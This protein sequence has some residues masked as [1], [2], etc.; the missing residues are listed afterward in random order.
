[1]AKTEFFVGIFSLG[2]L[3]VNLDFIKGDSSNELTIF[4]FTTLSNLNGWTEQSDTVREVGMSKASFVLQKTKVFQRAVFFSLLNPQ[5][6]GAGFAGYRTNTH[7]DLRCYSKI[8]L[9]CRGQ[10][11]NF[12]YKIVVRHKNQNNEPH[13][14]FEQMFQAPNSG[15]FQNVDL[16]LS[17]FEA[18]YRGRRVNNSEPLDL[19][20]ITN[21]EIQI[22]GGV[23]LPVKQWGV[24][25][26]EINTVKAVN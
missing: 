5:P 18:Y 20:N 2:L 21:F 13:P 16:E 7:L 11:Q 14:S 1:M 26:L 12:G 4:D 15:K 25:A 9:D 23:Y 17:N 22:Y 3:L 6:N 24:S 19:S 10:G 8:R